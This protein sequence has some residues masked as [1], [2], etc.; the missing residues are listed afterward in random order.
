MSMLRPGNNRIYRSLIL[1]LMTLGWVLDSSGGPAKMCEAEVVSVRP[2][3]ISDKEPW[4]LY[5][6]VL[7]VT[8]KGDSDSI[9]HCTQ[10]PDALTRKPHSTIAQFH[11]RKGND[12]WK[13]TNVKMGSSLVGEDVAISPGAFLDLTTQL[14]VNIEDKDAIYRVSMRINIGKGEEA[15][16]IAA[17]FRIP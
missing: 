7:R 2:M 6:I 10:S 3:G 9:V 4:K 14:T 12:E 16:V 15:Q 5:Q 17:T 1:A 11:Y 13:A 8:N